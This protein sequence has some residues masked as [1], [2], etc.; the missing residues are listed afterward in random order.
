MGSLSKTCSVLNVA[1]ELPLE[2][3]RL[4]PSKVARHFKSALPSKKVRND[5]NIKPSI[6]K[7][8]ASRNAV[9]GHR[10]SARNINVSV[11]RSM[12]QR[13][14]G[15]ASKRSF[16]PMLRQNHEPRMSVVSGLE[17]MLSADALRSNPD[18]E[19]IG[20]AFVDGAKC[21]IDI[22]PHDD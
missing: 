14:L 18:D 21:D 20:S 22:V 17:Q 5:S 2:N 1:W 8:M 3:G 7:S 15:M 4:L 9:G 16:N 19:H 13:V 10:Q 12:T 11:H 6:A